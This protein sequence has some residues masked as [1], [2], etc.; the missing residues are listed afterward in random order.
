VATTFGMRSHGAILG[1]VFFCD[2]LG[3]A[4][5]PFLAGYIYDVTRGYDLAFL[6][7]A[8]LGIINLAAILFLRPLKCREETR[9]EVCQS[10]IY[11][12]SKRKEEDNG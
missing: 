5:G 3:G 11:C 6:L 2:T 12:H 4:V 9:E 1:L 7:C 8:I 10:S